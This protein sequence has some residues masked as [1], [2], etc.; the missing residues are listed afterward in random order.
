MNKKKSLVHKMNWF[1]LPTLVCSKIFGFLKIEEK[2][3]AKQV[4]K[5]WK[6]LIERTF[7]RICFYE[8]VWPKPCHIRWID[9]A[10]VNDLDKI[11]VAEP[12]YE[13]RGRCNVSHYL[14]KLANPLDLKLRK[15]YL[16]RL[17]FDC[18]SF[19][20]KIDMFKQLDELTLEFLIGNSRLKQ[21]DRLYSLSLQ[22]ISFKQVTGA[23]PKLDTPNLTRLIF[24]NRHCI[25]M[26]I[27]RIVLAYPDSIVYLQCEYFN[28]PSLTNLEHLICQ[29]I[30]DSVEFRNHPKLK[31]LE[32]YPINRPDKSECS[33]SR[34][35]KLRQFGK[36]KR[37]LE[38]FI[39]GF[40]LD[41][42]LNWSPIIFNWIDANDFL[43]GT[44]GEFLFILASNFSR[45]SN[46]IPWS[47]FVTYS[48][49][50]HEFSGLIP[51]S[52]FKIFANIQQLIVNGPSLAP[53]EL[54]ANKLIDFL[55]ECHALQTLELLHCDT[56]DPEFYHRFSTIIPASSLWELTIKQHEFIDFRIDKFENL[57]VFNLTGSSLS[58][59]LFNRSLEIENF[60]FK[61]S[62]DRL[63]LSISLCY[64]PVKGTNT[65]YIT[66]W[67]QDGGSYFKMHPL[68]DRRKA[69]DLLRADERAKSCLV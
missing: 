1:D 21:I 5:S 30:D 12:S 16:F 44:N 45:L 22:T 10:K 11:W 20:E 53:G 63:G 64:C 31:K 4:C 15:I 49:L 9:G 28:F 52:F 43:K 2:L 48:T 68:S 65:L 26:Y 23:L 61:Y 55:N 62:N 24:W 36:S 37:E 27:Q 3:K 19:L 14:S 17:P 38:I 67:S 41:S 6:S 25:H 7:Q 8:D 40:R 69:I 51:K 60:N 54:N 29:E 13:Y 50:L 59:Q 35:E 42:R 32:Y 46:Q 57:Q 56:L 39:S 33:L 66:G 34:I 47:L 18:S 58:F